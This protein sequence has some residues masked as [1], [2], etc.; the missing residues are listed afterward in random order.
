MKL[1]ED[2]ESK[3]SE[4]K[5][6]RIFFAFAEAQESLGVSRQTIYKLMDEGLPSQKIG[7]K[8]VFLKEDVVK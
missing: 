1:G 7:K 6:E 8:W 5:T 2:G 3:E 4:K